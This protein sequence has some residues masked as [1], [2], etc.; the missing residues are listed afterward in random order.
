MAGPRWA[1]GVQAWF[2]GSGEPQEVW[3]GK[4]AKDGFTPVDSALGCRVETRR[5]EE[6]LDQ[7]RG[8]E[9]R[10]WTPGP[11]RSH[12]HSGRAAG[13]GAGAGLG[14]EGERA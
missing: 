2:L 11:H 6:T 13:S 14:P 12:V 9:R 5:Q 7:G 4:G 1:R 3:R 8:S 10:S